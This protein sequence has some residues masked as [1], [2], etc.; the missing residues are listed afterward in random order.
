MVA[1]NAQKVIRKIDNFGKEI[2]NYAIKKMFYDDLRLNNK[3][4]MDSLYERKLNKIK[5]DKEIKK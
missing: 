2:L 5:T 1:K 3:F 4:Y